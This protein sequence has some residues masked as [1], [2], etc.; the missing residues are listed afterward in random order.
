VSIYLVEVLEDPSLS[1]VLGDVVQHAVGVRRHVLFHV[2]IVLVL[3]LQ[4]VLNTN[5]Q[6]LFSINSTILLFSVYST[7]PNFGEGNSLLFPSPQFS[8]P[9]LLSPLEV[10]LLPST[11]SRYK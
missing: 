11:C 3:Q 2:V 6:L 7:Y 4:L 10:G 5:I 1:V 8:L 9:S